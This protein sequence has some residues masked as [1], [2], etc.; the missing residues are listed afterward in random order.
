MMYILF[1]IIVALVLLSGYMIY[2]L[3]VRLDKLSTKIAESLAQLDKDVQ[4]LH[5][6]QKTLESDVKKIFNEFQN[7]QKEAVRRQVNKE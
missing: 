2:T 4:T 7:T 3:S 6:N 5:T 1:A